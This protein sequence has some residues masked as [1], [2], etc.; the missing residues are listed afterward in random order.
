MRHQAVNNMRASQV[1]NMKDVKCESFLF[2]GSVCYNPYT[3]AL[4]LY[5]LQFHHMSV[6]IQDY[7]VLPCTH[8]ICLY[9]YIMLC[10]EYYFVFSSKHVKFYYCF[11][12]NNIICV[13]NETQEQKT[14]EK[15]KKKTEKRE[16]P[17]YYSRL[18]IFAWNLFS[19]N[20]ETT[21]Y[22]AF[23]ETFEIT[24]NASTFYF[25]HFVQYEWTLLSYFCTILCL[26]YCLLIH[27]A[28]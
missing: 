23:C 12:K 25:L 6:V 24:H 17:E 7:F 28:L 11:S 20:A 16:R 19:F 22:Q 5:H 9:T 8:F 1:Y 15:G 14:N 4:F 27:V 18:H 10:I 21:L 26:V 13:F 3:W 2:F